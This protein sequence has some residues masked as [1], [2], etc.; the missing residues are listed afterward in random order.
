MPL[1]RSESVRNVL[2]RAGSADAALSSDAVA[3]AGLVLKSGITMDTHLV[4][5]A[6]GRHSRL[7]EW[8]TDEGFGEPPADTVNSKLGYATRMYN[9]PHWNKA[10][11]PLHLLSQPVCAAVEWGHRCCAFGSTAV[12]WGRLEVVLSRDKVVCCDRETLD[13]L[14]F[15]PM[16]PKFTASEVADQRCFLRRTTRW[17]STSPAT[18]G[19]ATA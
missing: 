14:S 9:I 18:L 10:W 8:L 13:I 4:V 17:R 2:H 19:H 3:C 12:T 11:H 7:P 5:D 6:S 16:R 15:A 1:K